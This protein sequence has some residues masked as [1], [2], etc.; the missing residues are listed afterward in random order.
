[1]DLAI[2]ASKAVAGMPLLGLLERPRDAVL[3]YGSHARGDAT[4]HSDIDVL[5]LMPQRRPSYR[6]GR[7]SVVTVTAE[8]LRAL[9]S[10]G[11]LFALHLRE[12]GVLVRD[13]SHALEDILTSVR[14]PA[15]YD[16]LRESFEV[17]ASLLDVDAHGFGRNPRGFTQL[18]VYLLR[19]VLYLR[20]AESGRPL[21]SMHKVAEHLHDRRALDVFEHRNERHGDLDFF[22]F[23][24]TMIEDHLGA[25]IRNDFGS[26]EALAAG[27][28]RSPLASALALRLLA[29]TSMTYED[30]LPDGIAA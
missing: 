11:S 7:V 3:L 19:S 21:F 28:H 16:Q 14:P 22:R 26:V 5:Q 25:P 8:S 30:L 12:E 13:T 15:T 10:S 29:G 2:T 1:M 27:C 17:A 4:S 18:A 23:V 24:R 9:A 6:R 20:C